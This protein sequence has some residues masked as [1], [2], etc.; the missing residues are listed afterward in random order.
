MWSS[1]GQYLKVAEFHGPWTPSAC[2]DLTLSEIEETKHHE[3]LHR[4]SIQE[5][6]RSAVRRHAGAGRCGTTMSWSRSTQ[7]GSIFW[8]PRSATASSSSSCPI[9][10]PSSWA[11]TW[12]EPWFGVGSKVRQFKPGDEVYARP[13]DG[14]V[15]TFAEFI[16]MNEADV[17]LKPKNLSMEEAASIPLVGSDRLAGA[18]RESQPEEGAESF[19]PCRLRR[20]GNIRH[21]AGKASRCDGRDDDE[22]GECRVG[23]EPRRRCRHRLQEAGLREGPVRLRRRPEQPGRRHARKIPERAEARRQAHL[24]LRSAGSRISPGNKD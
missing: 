19:H 18:G 9:A 10:R 6:G 12:P 24:D 5:E 11:T 21:P 14:R 17:A 3:G 1:S 23:Q 4:R 16:A 13:R 22:H 7:P 2:R 8:I 20:R 15:G